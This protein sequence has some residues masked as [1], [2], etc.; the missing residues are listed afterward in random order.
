MAVFQNAHVQATEHPLFTGFP[1]EPTT[2]SFTIAI[3]VK[4][5]TK[6]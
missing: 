3:A 5:L 1:G 6:Q 2:N 4:D